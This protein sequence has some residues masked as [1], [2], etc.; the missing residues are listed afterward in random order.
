MRSKPSKI[1]KCRKALA[2]PGEQRLVL[3]TQ[4]FSSTL[5]LTGDRLD[6]FAFDAEYL[7]RLKRGDPE[8]VRHFISHFSNAI[9]LKLRN[10]VPERHLLEEIRQETFARVLDY[11]RSGKPIHYPERFGGFVLKFCNNVMLETLRAEFG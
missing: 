2:N 5:A 1:P 7:A 9:W 8:T 11:L 6:P 4:R 3:E 10:R